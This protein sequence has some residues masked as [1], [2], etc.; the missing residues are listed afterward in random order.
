MNK[1]PLDDQIQHSQLEIA[2][3]FH[4]VRYNIVTHCIKNPSTSVCVSL[5][6]LHYD[7]PGCVWKRDASVLLHNAN[8]SYAEAN[9]SKICGQI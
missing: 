9:K 5:A 7:T 4:L 3:F 1:R 2:G 8:K 6:S